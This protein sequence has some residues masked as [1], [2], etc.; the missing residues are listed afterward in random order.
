L[1]ASWHKT[2]KHAC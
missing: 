2:Y 1:N